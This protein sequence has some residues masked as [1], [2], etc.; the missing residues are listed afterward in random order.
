MMKTFL[1]RSG[2]RGELCSPLILGGADMITDEIAKKIVEAANKA[3]ANCQ[4]WVCD[5]CECRY[6]RNMSWNEEGES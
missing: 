5:E 1:F 6:W 2:N 4:E 3:C